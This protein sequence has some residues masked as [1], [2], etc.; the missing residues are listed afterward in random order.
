MLRETTLTISDFIVT[1]SPDKSEMVRVVTLRK[2]E[3]TEIKR[4]KKKTPIFRD[5][6]LKKH[7]IAC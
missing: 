1:G 4:L 5:G 6:Y 2:T 3:I 7:E